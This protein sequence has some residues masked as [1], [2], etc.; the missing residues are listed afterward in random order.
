PQIVRWAD[1]HHKTTGYWPRKGTAG[2]IPNAEGEKWRNVDAALKQG[3]RGLPG[4]SSL[5]KLLSEKRAVPHIGFPSDVTV[6]QLLKW[7]D[8]HREK[9]GKWPTRTSGGVHGA[10]DETWSALDA[11]L[12]LGSRGLPGGSSL[13][14]LPGQERGKR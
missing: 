11:S 5:A 12:K 7:A 10:V 4:G 13:A 3:L 2:K 9:T 8:L 6:K 1:I 14:V